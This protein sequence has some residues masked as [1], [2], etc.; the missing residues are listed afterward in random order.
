MSITQ[1]VSTDKAVS[2]MLWFYSCL[3]KKNTITVHDTIKL[4][5]EKLIIPDTVVLGGQACAVAGGLLGAGA[6]PALVLRF[7]DKL[8]GTAAAVGAKVA[9][10]GAIAL[11]FF[12]TA[13]PLPAS[14][15]RF[16]ALSAGKLSNTN[17]FPP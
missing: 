17:T 13:H 16:F 5:K 4:V 15:I 1:T 6:N 3:C 10:G 8:L 9:A 11:E 2:I 12:A 14:I 7:G